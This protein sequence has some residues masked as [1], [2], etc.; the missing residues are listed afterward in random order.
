MNRVYFAVIFL[1]IA[2]CVARKAPAPAVVAAPTVVPTATPIVVVAPPLPTPATPTPD[3]EFAP[4][5]AIVVSQLQRLKSASPERDVAT[6]WARED[7]RF[8]GVNG[9][10]VSVP[11]VPKEKIHSAAMRGQLHP[12]EGTAETP[13]SDEQRELNVVA[14]KYA[15]RYNKL[16]LAKLDAQPSAIP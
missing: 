5:Q 7:T 1:L 8:L 11:G 9:Y 2:G 15:E 12:I 14:W 10:S 3:P 16:L 6:A 4:R 13:Q